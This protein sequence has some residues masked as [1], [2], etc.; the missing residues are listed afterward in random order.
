MV[1]GSLPNLKV[2][3]GGSA[4]PWSRNVPGDFFI[5]LDR[6]I[7]IFLLTTISLPKRYETSQVIG[8]QVLRT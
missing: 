1:D 4:L 3:C 8:R 5:L 6:K 7:F 2:T